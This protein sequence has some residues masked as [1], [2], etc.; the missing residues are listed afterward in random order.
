MK[1]DLDEIMDRLNKSYPTI[2]YDRNLVEEVIYDIVNNKFSHCSE[3]VK[4]NI[5]KRLYS[6]IVKDE[7]V[8]EP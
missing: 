2:E 8:L 7:D 1:D 3:D 6:S 5:R 4:A